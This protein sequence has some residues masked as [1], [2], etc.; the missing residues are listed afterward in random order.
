[1]A[2]VAPSPG[3]RLA[4]L[5]PFS[6]VSLILTLWFLV[7]GSVV[8]PDWDALGFD[9]LITLFLFFQIAGLA[10]ARR[11]LAQLPLPISLAYFGVGFVASSFLFTVLFAGA[12]VSHS[13][14]VEGSLISVV[15]LM[16]VVATSEE[17][18]FRGA[19]VRF[20]GN[21]VTEAISVLV[22]AIIF[23]LFH[24]VAYGAGIYGWASFLALLFPFIWGISFGFLFLKTR[25]IAL[26]IA[27]HWA[28]NLALLGVNV[29]GFLGV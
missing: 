3:V 22:S 5:Y 4:L 11:Q 18:F 13:F 14:P 28:L 25:S 21:K 6:T 15:A 27:L 26:V 9:S 23:A 12:G 20:T 2:M 8:F 29:F 16:F 1:M 24:I 17:V 19:L 7:S 10:L